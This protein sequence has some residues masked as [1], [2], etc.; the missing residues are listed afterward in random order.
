MAMCMPA[1]WMMPPRRWY[2]ERIQMMQK[3]SHILLAAV[4]TCLISGCQNSDNQTISEQ[5][6]SPPSLIEQNAI[7]PGTI[8][9]T[10]DPTA[11]YDAMQNAAKKACRNETICKVVIFPPETVLPTQFPMTER[12]VAEQIGNYT[13]NRNTGADDLLANCEVVKNAPEAKC[14]AIG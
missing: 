5:E 8:F 7:I 10:F 1:R 11:G 9:A 2:K 6:H 3:K 13:L 4:V 14:M 12:E